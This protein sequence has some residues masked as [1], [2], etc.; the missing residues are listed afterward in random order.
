MWSK[1]DYVVW[2]WANILTTL[3]IVVLAIE[4]FTLT[5]ASPFAVLFYAIC[6]WI[7]I[8]YLL[9]ISDVEKKDCIDEDVF[10]LIFVV[11][12]FVQAPIVYYLAGN[13]WLLTSDMY[14]LYAPLWVVVYWLIQITYGIAMNFRC[15]V[16]E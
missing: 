10:G 9:N 14:W 4:Q 13:Q 8:S 1:I 5:V 16:E 6:G 12:L 3:V 11:A 7:V 2:T 15:V